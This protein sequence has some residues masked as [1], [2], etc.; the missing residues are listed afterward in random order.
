MGKRDKIERV[1]IQWPNGRVEEYKNLAS[2][3][4]YDC[5]ESE[6]ITPGVGF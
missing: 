6:G 3:K 4:T 5:V 2:G 1:V